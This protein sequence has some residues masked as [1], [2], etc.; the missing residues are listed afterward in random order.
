MDDI[1]GRAEEERLLV[2]YRLLRSD[3][4]AVLRVLV[5]DLPASYE[6]VSYLLSAPSGQSPWEMKSQ[7]DV[8][9]NDA[10]GT[11]YTM[12]HGRGKDQE[13]REV[14]VMRRRSRDYLFTG[15]YAASDT[16]ARD[17]IRRALESLTWQ[18]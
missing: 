16:K 11:R 14:L 9:I 6:M 7:V 5:I 10:N 17:Q 18:K 3:N 13:I 4:P 8:K 1:P 2:E 12:D 15:M